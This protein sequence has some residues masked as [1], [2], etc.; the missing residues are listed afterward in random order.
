ME[1]G[2]AIAVGPSKGHGDGGSLL[3]CER[4]IR[5]GGSHIPSSHW[6]HNPKK[7]IDALTRSL[8]PSFVSLMKYW[9]QVRRLPQPIHGT[10]ELAQ[11]MMQRKVPP[12]RWK[13]A[14]RLVA[15]RRR[16]GGGPWPSGNLP[17][18]WHHGESK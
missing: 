13:G 4:P 7:N 14:G 3:G 12:I 9:I 5:E 10:A 15:T 8:G 6:R 1:G 18:P 16:A 2:E 11:A 17:L